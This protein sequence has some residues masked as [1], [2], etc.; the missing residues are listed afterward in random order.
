MTHRPVQLLAA[1]AGGVVLTAGTMAL[2][3]ATPPHHHPGVAACA[4]A[5]IVGGPYGVGVWG[6]ARPPRRPHPRVFAACAYALIV[7][8]PY[9]VG[10]WVLARRPRDRFAR[11]LL[12]AAVAWS[13]VSLVTSSDPLL[14]SLGRVGLWLAEPVLICLLLAFP[15]GR[16]RTRTD[17]ALVAAA[18]LLAGTLYLPTAL[19]SAF[20][21]PGA[22][23]ICGTD[24]PDNALQLTAIGWG[25]VDSVVRPLRETLLVGLY[26]A[27]AI[28]LARRARR[29][30]PALRR[31]MTP[32]VLAA[33]ARIIVTAAYIIIPRRPPDAA[34]L[35]ALGWLYV[36]T[37]PLVA[38]GFGLGLVTRQLR[39]AG[40]LE[41]L[42][43]R[44]RGHA[45]VAQLRPALA[46][47]LEDP[48][49]QLAF[50]RS[51]EPGRWVDANGWPVA[52]P[53]AD[54]DVVVTP[55]DRDGQRVAAIVHDGA[56]AQDPAL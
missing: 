47:A 37:L 14:Y 21:V 55:I 51:G 4:H 17:R 22:G 1:G 13:T 48:S 12:G 7:G 38:L 33:G 25:S 19:V 36:L 41:D 40:A 18:G 34:A 24:C 2:T 49:L 30:G 27:V 29:A 32:V 26:A 44:L 45:D 11:M 3:L 5:P 28:V 20:P 46:Q 35:E 39:A 6:L 8:V 23:S 9:G 16:L 43:E 56:L 50:W 42:A 31:A 15:S 52:A 54:D 53:R 10:L